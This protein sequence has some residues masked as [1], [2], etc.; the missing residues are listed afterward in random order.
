VNNLQYMTERRRFSFRGIGPPT[1]TG[2]T[3]SMA[4]GPAMRTLER[5]A[6]DPGCLSTVPASHGSECLKFA[7]EN[8]DC[9]V[10]LPVPALP[11]QS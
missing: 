11:R 8:A 4:V 2:E 5:Y 1:W 10:W 7:Y 3:L 9:H 6:E